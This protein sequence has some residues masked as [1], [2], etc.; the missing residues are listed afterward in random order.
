VR[1]GLSYLEERIGYR[2]WTRGN[3]RLGG[4]HSLDAR[5]DHNIDELM[6]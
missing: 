5:H 1:Y 6:A 4:I 3:G 2:E